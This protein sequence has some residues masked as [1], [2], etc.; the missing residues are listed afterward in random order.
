MWG[1]LSPSN[2]YYNLELKETPQRF[3]EKIAKTVF[4]FSILD[5]YFCPF[6]KS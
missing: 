4:G 2:I 3:D 6:L 5:I 1:S